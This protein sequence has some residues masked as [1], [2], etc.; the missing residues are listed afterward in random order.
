[1]FVPV[2]AAPEPEPPGNAPLT[3]S[4]PRG[5]QSEGASIEVEIAGVV[6][7]VGRD[8]DP[9]PIAAVIGALRAGS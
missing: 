6:V 1:M 5:R 7:R 4:K 8:A 3:P 2:I 9:A